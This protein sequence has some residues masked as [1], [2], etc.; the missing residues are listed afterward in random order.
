MKQASYSLRIIWHERNRFLPGILA[1]SFSALLIAIQ[2]GLLLG[3]FSTVTI[4]IDRS[5][6][7]LWVGFPGVESIDL[8]PPIPAEW[9]ARL[10]AQPEVERTEIY[11]RGFVLWPKPQGGAEMCAVIGS[12]LDDDALGAIQDLTPEMRRGLSEPGAV[13]VDDA[14]RERLG[15]TGVG[16]VAEVVGCRVRVIGFVRGLK[17]LAGVFVFCSVQTARRLLGPAGLPAD[18]VMYLLARCHKPADAAT[19][20]QRL[21]SYSN[22]SAYTRDELSL[23]SRLHWLT[24][25]KAG[26]ALSCAALLG[27]FVGAAVTSQTLYAATAASAREYAVLEAL[28]IPTWH[29]IA[30]VLMQSFWVGLF[31]I[32]LALPAIF[33]LDHTF[34]ALG[35]KVLLPGWLLGLTIAVTLAMALI[36]GLIALR[37]LR[38]AEPANLLR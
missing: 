28:G 38:L 5:S 37:S 31:G 34:E 8:C 3:M 36:S 6:A 25:T 16:H 17:G 27:L 11:L 13:I 4:P 7:D 24:K 12:R 9:K 23:R 22:M 29:V 32:I 26:L 35:S 33:V 18:Q 14:E 19:V 21:R 10:D 30:M 15:I 1:V 2:C 20:V